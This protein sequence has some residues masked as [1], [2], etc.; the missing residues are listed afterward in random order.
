MIDNRCYYYSGC[1]A[2]NQLTGRRLKTPG[3]DFKEM[4]RFEVLLATVMIK[5]MTLLIEAVSISEASVCIYLTTQCSIPE[6][7]HLPSLDGIFAKKT[8]ISC[9]PC[10]LLFLIHSL[11]IVS[12]QL[13]ILCFRETFTVHCLCYG[14]G[15]HS[16]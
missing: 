14:S 9:W 2:G 15:S 5:F 16:W 8:E 13:C 4:V 7:S 10:I 3:L 6:D 11:L 1:A 12:S